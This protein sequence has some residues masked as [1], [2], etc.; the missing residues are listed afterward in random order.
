MSWWEDL[1]EYY[2]VSKEDAIALGIRKTGRRPN[3]PGSKTC[4]PV[5]GKNFEELWDEKPRDTIQQKMDFY[6]D[7]GA[8]QVFRQ[9]NYRSTFDYGK[10]FFPYIKSKTT[11]LLE[12]GCGVAP[13]T[14]YIVENKETIGDI[15]GMSFALV[16]VVGEHLE[17]AKWRL[18]NKAPDVKFDFYEIT[19]ENPIPKFTNNFD[20]ICIMDVLEHLPNPYDVMLNILGYLNNEAVMVMTWVDKSGGKSGGPDL[21]E[22]ENERKITMKLICDNFDL[23]KNGSI[24]I[25]RKKLNGK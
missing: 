18:K 16:D 7:I 6:K 19:A 11:S 9:C 3:L 14:N 25:Y 23:L 12:Y 13:L 21:E 20:I 4:K 24:Q 5:S 2:G 8:W 17:F 10:L 1:V 15:K 22:S